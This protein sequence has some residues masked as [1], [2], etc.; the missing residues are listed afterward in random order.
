MR[1]SGHALPPA[2]GAILPTAARVGYRTWGRRA[3]KVPRNRNSIPRDGSATRLLLGLVGLRFGFLF[4]ILVA[5]LILL[6]RRWY[7]HPDGCSI[8]RQRAAAKRSF[9]QEAGAG[10]SAGLSAGAMPGKRW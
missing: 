5:H 3:S 4:G 10:L 8:S 1:A 2:L 7:L 9:L 6:S